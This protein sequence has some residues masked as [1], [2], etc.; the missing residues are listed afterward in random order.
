[1]PDVRT[2]PQQRLERILGWTRAHKLW[3]GIILFSLWIV[4]EIA[5]L[6]YADVVRLKRTQPTETAFMRMHQEQAAVEGKAFKKIHRWVP[7][8][9]ISR[10]AVNAVIVAEDG[11]FWSHSG[12]DWFEVRESIER[13]ISEGRAARGA[14]TIT[15]QLVKNLYLSPSKNPLRK[16]KEW[17][18][19]WWM[20]Q[21]L[22]K[23]RILEL[24]LNLIEWGRGIYGI[25]AASQTYF[26]K[27]ASGL[28]R[29][30]GARLAAVIP[31]PRIFRVDRETRYLQRRTQMILNRM[32]ARGY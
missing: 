25:E 20:E 17:I 14:S 23:Q 24:Y 6:P 30:E 10:D 28:T 22:S 9:R 5:M 31:N 26:G 27:S 7:F 12:F 3:T 2:T 8:N 13:N 19:T 21:T 15:Q 4:L 16:L 11:T 1:M 29:E 32:A 18:L